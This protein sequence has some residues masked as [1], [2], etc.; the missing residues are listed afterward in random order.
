MRV[1]GRCVARVTA[2][3]AA[4]LLW[5][6]CA[7]AQVA[8]RAALIIGND[9]YTGAPLKNA[10]N[11]ARLVA[12]ALSM[13]GFRTDLALDLTQRGFEETIDR[14]LGSLQP[15]AIA[16][17]FYAGH[18]VQIDGENYLLP[19]DYE[20][21]DVSDVRFKGYSAS[22]LHERVAARGVRLQIMI[23]DA[24]RNNPFGASRSSTRGLA[25][26]GSGQKGSLIAFSTAPGAVASD[27]PQNT[28]SAFTRQLINMM[29]EP[30]LTLDALFL[31]VRQR[32]N[33]STGGRQTPWT[34]SSLL[35]EF[36][37]VPVAGQRT[38]LADASRQQVF[39]EIANSTDAPELL[40][41]YLR[42]YPNGVH[43]NL[44]RT[45]LA[46]V[47]TGPV[48][49][50]PAAAANRPS[51]A[52]YQFQNLSGR[53]DANWIG[54]AI[55]ESLRTDLAGAE[56]V[57]VLGP[58]NVAAP[59]LSATRSATAP[60]ELQ[61]TFRVG[62]SYLIVG[63]GTERRIRI[64]TI[65]TRTG[66]SASMGGLSETGTE[67]RLVELIARQG[68]G[69]RRLLKVPSPPQAEALASLAQT[70][71]PTA[72]S[73][74]LYAEALDL[75]RRFEWNAASEVLIRLTTQQPDFTLGYVRLSEV[76]GALGFD[77]KAREMSDR[78]REMA[79]RLPRE[80]Q[81]LV[82]AQ[83]FTA[84]GEWAG[85]RDVWRTMFRLYP[86]NLDYGLEL[87]RVQFRG[88]ERRAALDT[89][90]AL[91]R[92]IPSAAVDPRVDLAEAETRR[93]LSQAVE[94]QPLAQRAAERAKA[95][96]SQQLAAD[97]KL[98][99]AW[100]WRGQ[101]NLEQSIAAN[102]EARRLYQLTGDRSGMAAAMVQL[103]SD[104]RAQK[105]YEQAATFLND[106]IDLARSIG[107]R[108]RLSAGHNNLAS[109]FFSERRFDDARVHYE[110][111]LM[112]SR[113]IQDKGA[114]ATALNNVASVL[115]MQGD[116]DGAA[117]LDREA[118]AIR[119]E[120]GAP[121]PIADS[122]ANVAET[123][124]DASQLQSAATLYE[125]S[126]AIFEKLNDRSKMAY[127]LH[128]LGT[129]RLWQGL[130]SDAR[131]L[132]LQ[133]R[134]IRTELKEAEAT[135]S[136]L[137]VAQ[138][139][140][141]ESRCREAA[142]RATRVRVAE[143]DQR[144]VAQA[145]S[146]VGE[147]L[148]CEGDHTAA[149]RELVGD[150]KE[151]PDREALMLAVARARLYAASA[152]PGEAASAVEESRVIAKRVHSRFLLL[153][154]D[155]TAVE[156]ASGKTSPE[157]RADIEQRAAAAGAGLIMRRLQERAPR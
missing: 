118:L 69:V 6:T 127:V 119:R 67:D 71:P 154:A 20:G 63:T 120:I 27:D 59:T 130:I 18:G 17:V 128:G 23:L 11:D 87:A 57:R 30:G 109:L 110:Q 84:R 90:E 52:V 134:D 85:A 146:I 147:A 137:L 107:D 78:A 25:V 131:R 140:L 62:G 155:A 88:A 61:A 31:R 145:R 68:S 152:R 53:A 122:L 113:E 86:D 157:T 76:W 13:V 39:W 101:G 56:T 47:R 29:F 92:D 93:A 28:N 117:P 135:E 73:N 91:R 45:K 143:Q 35:E 15:G 97:A 100:A 81:L 2:A 58:S 9:T 32:V 79:D 139:D 22:R 106:A 36:S 41:L 149:E 5:A 151:V 60:R 99:E 44:V 104:Y 74:R 1:T 112:I 50:V 129:V 125:E 40:E 42:E 115:Y 116:P 64:N 21:R 34:N 24:C 14:F 148:T 4:L 46:A 12:D 43:A 65:V 102:E 80:Q 108:R 153:V 7:S 54:T 105:A 55:A 89:I 82:D 123:T 66:D 126:L 132:A 26:M 83:Y 3:L 94:A 95:A 77:L 33:Q 138:I 156:V 19:V 75:M 98:Q 70:M 96:G 38:D 51:V 121:I 37:F 111:A 136:D 144:L 124:F 150:L 133:A 114:T 8:T 72:V 48:R 49:P 16:L 141:S 142:D 10:R 103:G